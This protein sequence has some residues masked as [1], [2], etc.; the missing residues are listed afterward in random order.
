[1]KTLYTLV[2]AA[3]I[4][5]SSAIAV[6]EPVEPIALN[7]AELDGVTAGLTFVFL[8]ANAV[9]SAEG[10]GLFVLN[11]TTTSAGAGALVFENFFGPLDFAF[12]GTAAESSS[13]S[14]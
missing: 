5:G 6:A 7:N 14:F 3:L 13:S 9:A 11:N 2:G 12:G 8:N 10:E 4:A 1:M